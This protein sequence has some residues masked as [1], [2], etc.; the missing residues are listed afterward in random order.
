[1]MPPPKKAFVLAAGKGERMRPLTDNCPKPLLEV[2]GITMLDRALDA[3]AEAGVEEAVVNTFYLGEMI[4]RH[5][6]NRKH[7]KI[8]ISREEALLDTGGGVRKAIEFFGREPF[9]V[10]NADVVWTDGEESAL[11]R[12]AKKWDSSKMDLLLLLQTTK[13]LPAYAG[14][15]DYYLADG[16]DQP[17]FR[18]R[19]KKPA[20][21]IFSGARIVHPRLFEGVAE[22]IFSFLDL[23]HKAEAAGRLYGLRH[24]GEW[25]HVGTPEALAETNRILSSRK[26][27]KQQAL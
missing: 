14:K 4:E 15:G 20:N 24:D 21:Y 2:G 1:M 26:K 22:G 9:Y 3:L 16:L 6:R 19:S 10:L 7:P 25:H 27:E 8:I 18:A 11:R 12:L 23:F 13:D 17:V 5:L